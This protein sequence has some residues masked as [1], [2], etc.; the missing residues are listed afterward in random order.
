MLRVR[1]RRVFRRPSEKKHR[2][3]RTCPSAGFNEC[4]NL[5]SLVKLKWKDLATSWRLR[6]NRFILQEKKNTTHLISL[7]LDYLSINHWHIINCT[8][9]SKVTSSC[10]LEGS[11]E[12][13]ITSVFIYFYIMW[14]AWEG[15]LEIKN[16]GKWPEQH[17]NV[18]TLYLR[19]LFILRLKLDTD[20]R[21]WNTS[22]KHRFLAFVSFSV[23]T[24][25][26]EQSKTVNLIIFQ[27]SIER[28][29]KLYLE[30]HFRTVISMDS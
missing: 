28:N 5:P 18:K 8:N 14:I 24:F 26:T 12:P 2:Y 6:V 1:I 11:I 20:E 10:F 22:G 13:F 25:Q 7:I 29:K 21:D 15:R 3:H 17:A 23:W 9:V 30:A 16:R 27:L 19:Q 4:L